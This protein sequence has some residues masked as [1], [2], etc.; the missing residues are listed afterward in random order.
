M[1]FEYNLPITLSDR[2]FLFK[3]GTLL[4]LPEGNMSQNSSLNFNFKV[5]KDT[6]FHKIYFLLF[7]HCKV[8]IVALSSK[9]RQIFRT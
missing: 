4:S 1:V 7:F 9:Y 8:R 5:G 2:D 6:T 3:I